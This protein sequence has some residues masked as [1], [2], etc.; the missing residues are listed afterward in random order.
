MEFIKNI[1]GTIDQT[2]IDRYAIN[3]PDITDEKYR[4]I[5]KNSVFNFSADWQ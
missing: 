5:V 1:I 3:I 2:C 4:F